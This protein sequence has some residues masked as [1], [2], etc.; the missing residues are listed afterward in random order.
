MR[1]PARPRR[2][3]DDGDAAGRVEDVSDQRVVRCRNR[4]AALVEVKER[5]RP[6]AIVRVAQCAPS[7]T[8]GCPTAA[9][10]TLR[11]TTPAR[12]MIVRMYG[13]ALNVLL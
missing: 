8:Y 2:G 11:P 12:T 7:L 10:A 3:A 5:K 13:S 4:T 6:G 1:R 9:G